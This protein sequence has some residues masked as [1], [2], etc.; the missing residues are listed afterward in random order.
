M[1][2]TFE[3]LRDI[4]VNE[5]ELPP[6]RLTRD[7]RLEDIEIDSLAAME[8]V[9]SL[10]DRFDVT[11]DERLETPFATLGDIADYIDRLCAER[12]GGA[13]SET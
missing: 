8:L 5:Y 2:A 10:E 13:G 12:D 11:A 3:G 1:T 4:L 6:E 7:T 9:F